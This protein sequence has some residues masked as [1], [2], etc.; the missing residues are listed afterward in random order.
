MS[1]VLQEVKNERD[2][3]DAKW[4]VQN[5]HPVEWLSILGEEFGEVCK[6]SCEAH[7]KYENGETWKNYREELIQTAAVAVAMVECL[8]RNGEPG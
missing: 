3:Q 7:F 5:H 8:D 1:S 4:G 6:A 2:R